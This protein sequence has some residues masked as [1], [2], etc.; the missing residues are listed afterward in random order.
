MNINFYSIIKFSQISEFH[1]IMPI[2]NIPNVISNGI[3][4]YEEV[5]R[6]EHNSIAM[7]EV[8]ERRDKIT[9]NGKNL[10]QYANLYFHARNPMMFKRKNKNICVLRINKNISRLP[11]VVFSDRNA[12]S[13][14][15]NFYTIKGVHQLDYESIFCKDWTDENEIR[16]YEM[17]SKKCAEILVPSKVDY[18]QI[19][20][21]YVKSESDKQILLDLG[22]D[23]QIDINKELFFK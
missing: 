5:Q 16:Y 18:P 19:I 3:L 14:Y 7:N 1:N 22:F 8:Q 10:H 15:A 4:S 11:N 21:A 2:D 23:K 6:I 20:G 9:L 17:K 13:E 12:S